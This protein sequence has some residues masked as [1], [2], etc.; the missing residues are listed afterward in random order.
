MGFKLVF[1]SD[2]YITFCPLKSLQPKMK[3]PKGHYRLPFD[4]GLIMN[5]RT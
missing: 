1:F 5:N 3:L 2:T 4:I